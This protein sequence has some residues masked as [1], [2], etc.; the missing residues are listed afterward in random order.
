MA[1]PSRRQPDNELYDRGCCLVHAAAAI[2]RA[3]GAARA[4]PAALGCIEAAFGE[5]L[6]AAA[7]R[8]QTA[9]AAT[10][11]AQPLGARTMAAALEARMHRGNAKLQRALG[12]RALTVRAFERAGSRRRPAVGAAREVIHSGLEEV[13]ES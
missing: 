8:E 10:S 9:A 3:S 12:A 4:L 11:A 13:N 6:A 5:L 1:R 7:A 2:S